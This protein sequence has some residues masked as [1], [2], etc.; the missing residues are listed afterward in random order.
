M[1]ARRC[2]LNRDV[3]LG[4]GRFGRNPADLRENAQSRVDKRIFTSSNSDLP[5]SDYDIF[6]KDHTRLRRAGPL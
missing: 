1:P 5:P 6:F 4:C 3:A 2:I